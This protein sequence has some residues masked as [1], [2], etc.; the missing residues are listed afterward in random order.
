MKLDDLNRDE[1]HALGSLVRL[2]L[3]SDGEFTEAEESK[4]HALG[5]RLDAADRIWSVISAS[6]QAHPDDAAMRASA[7]NVTRAPVRDLIRNALADIADD[8]TVTGSEKKLLEWLDQ[9]W[10]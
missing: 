8:G 5:Q 6:A 4:V 1:Q 3:R 10:R 7:A 2:M 9:A